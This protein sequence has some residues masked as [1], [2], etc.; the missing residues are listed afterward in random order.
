[1]LRAGG[2]RQESAALLVNAAVSREIFERTGVIVR[3]EVCLARHRNS[4]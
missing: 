3:I 4:G 1:V 2:A